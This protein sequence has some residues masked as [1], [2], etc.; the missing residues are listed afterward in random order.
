MGL[1]FSRFFLPLKAFTRLLSTLIRRSNATSKEPSRSLLAP[2]GRAEAVLSSNYHIPAE[3][4]SVDVVCSV[5]VLEHVPRPTA[6]AE[7]MARVLAPGG[8]LLLTADL[9]VAGHDRVRARILL[10]VAAVA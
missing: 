5:S 7:E 2:P 4:E 6:V 8:L 3:S 1:P 10:S 9:G